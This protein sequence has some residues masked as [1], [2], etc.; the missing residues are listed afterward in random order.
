M[1]MKFP[2]CLQLSLGIQALTAWSSSALPHPLLP[3]SSPWAAPGWKMGRPEAHTGFKT[4][5]HHEFIQQYNNIYQSVLNAFPKGSQCS[6]QLWPQL[7]FSVSPLWMVMANL[8]HLCMHLFFFPPR[9]RYFILW[10]SVLPQYFM[11]TTANSTH[12]NFHEMSSLS[13]EEILNCCNK[14]VYFWLNQDE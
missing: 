1:N 5:G 13:S 7:I 6:A 14:K 2:M 9:E 10:S 3:W 8:E 12:L 4:P 11:K